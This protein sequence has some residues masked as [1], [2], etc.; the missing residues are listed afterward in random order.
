MGELMIIF[1]SAIVLGH[2]FKIVPALL[3]M[4]KDW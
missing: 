4:G 3:T 1:G 2:L